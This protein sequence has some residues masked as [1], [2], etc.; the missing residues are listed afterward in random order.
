MRFLERK[1]RALVRP[2]SHA[3]S[4][5][6]QLIKS[7]KE[8]ISWARATAGAVLLHRRRWREAAGSLWSEATHEVATI[9]AALGRRFLVLE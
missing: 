8:H 7:S 4:I 6:T 1:V 2:A 9:V 5:F 3:K